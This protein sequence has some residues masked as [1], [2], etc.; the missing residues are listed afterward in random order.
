MP[1]LL[2][3]Y[4]ADPFQKSEMEAPS[5]RGSG[6][7][8]FSL[9]DNQMINIPMHRFKYTELTKEQV[10]QKLAAADAGPKCLS[11]LSNVLSG[12]S[13][14]IITDNGPV[15]N[16]LFKSKNKLTLAENS[17]A[18]AESSYG[19]LTLRQMVFFS[20]IVPKTQR[21][22]S[23]FID[24]DTNLATAPKPASSKMSERSVPAGSASP[25]MIRAW[26]SIP[27][28][29]LRAKSVGTT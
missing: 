23:V 10:G 26:G 18:A 27:S 22:F 7:V 6:Q 15:L 9:G 28:G 19:A 2:P 3:E 17:G 8:G 13:F 11:E 20:H 21:G 5:I 29:R 12:K 14:K 25:V 1:V 16:Y 24:L 4:S